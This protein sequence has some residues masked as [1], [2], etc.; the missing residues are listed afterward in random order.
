MGEEKDQ[1]KERKKLSIK[2]IGMDK[3]FVIIL[4]GILLVIFS[5]SPS[6][7]SKKNTETKSTS[8]AS[9]SNSE[10]TYEEQIESRLKRILSAMEGV[11]SVDV[12]VTLKASEELVVDKNVSSQKSSI[13]ESDSSGGSRNS[14]DEKNQSDTVIVQNENGDSPYVLQEKAPI[15]EGIVV[16]AEGGDKPQIVSEINEALQALFDISSHKI[17]VLKRKSVE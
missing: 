6:T 14:L 7:S 9:V 15:V 13:D 5:V 3:L 1:K 16:I 12:I 2:E 4:V 11:G 8:D 17:K 10:E